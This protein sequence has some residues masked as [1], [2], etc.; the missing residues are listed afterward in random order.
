MD[1]LIGVLMLS[2]IQAHIQFYMINKVSEIGVLRKGH[3][4]Q[5][6]L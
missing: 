1:F 4:I 2:V 5:N 6:Q 3:I